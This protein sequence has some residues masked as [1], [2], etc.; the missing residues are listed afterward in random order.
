MFDGTNYKIGR[1]NN[2]KKRIL[3]LKT[4][5]PN[6]KLLKENEFIAE[7]YFHELFCES[8]VGG[9][10]FELKYNDLQICNIL[11]NAK[12]KLESEMLMRFFHRKMKGSLKFKKSYDDF[13]H[14]QK[15]KVDAFINTKLPFGKFKGKKLKDMVDDE[16]IQYLQW[17]YRLPNLDSIIRISIKRYLEYKEVI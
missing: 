4:A 2:P 3:A 16:H 7:K 11:F 14:N 5:S 1:S 8:N 9:E 10:W 6:I 17:L 15:V 13:I 12:S